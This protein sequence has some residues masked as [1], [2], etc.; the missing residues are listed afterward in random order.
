VL[1][2]AT[3]LVGAVTRGEIRAVYQPQI[4]LRTG[5]L[6]AVEALCRWQHSQLGVIPPDQFIPVAEDAGFI[7]EIGVFMAEQACAAL[8]EWPIDV[9]V[10]VSPAQL[11]TPDFTEWLRGCL[12]A[13]PGRARRMTL[14]VT[15]SR[16]INDLAPLL[17][18]LEPL[19]A[20]GVGI[21]LDDFGTGHSSVK[22]LK[23][24]HGTEVKLDRSLVADDS[25]AVYDRMA[26]LVELAH[27]SG[28]RVVAEG[29][30]TDADLDRARALGCDRGQGYLLGRPVRREEI[31]R[32]LR[33]H[34]PR[35]L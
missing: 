34:P 31:S 16:P 11:E 12:G 7:H 15:E 30:E 24:L 23:R 3:S 13:K 18:R 1:D 14:E 21:A 26:A 8:D 5:R 4:D 25:P 2:L 27:R 29:I 35:W 22:Q 32:L 6:V 20:L 9:S 17:R 19:R 28:I 10:N 33:G